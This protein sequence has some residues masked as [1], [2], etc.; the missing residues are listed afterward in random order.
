MSPLKGVSQ[1][2]TVLWVSGHEDCWFK[3]LDWVLFS[4][5]HN[6]KFG[7]PNVGSEPIAL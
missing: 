2:A 1:I 6:L 5:V 4:Q 3:K 7:V